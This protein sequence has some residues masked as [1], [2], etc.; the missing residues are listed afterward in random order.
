MT[1]HEQKQLTSQDVDPSKSLITSYIHAHAQD[2][3]VPTDV[4]SVDQVIGVGYLSMMP[5]QKLRVKRLK[6]LYEHIEKNPGKMTDSM[7]TGNE[8][9]RPDLQNKR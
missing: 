9:I 5:A 6:W 1:R 7:S 3:T 8:H 4:D 2:E